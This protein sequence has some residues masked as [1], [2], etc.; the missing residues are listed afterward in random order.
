MTNQEYIKKFSCALALLLAQASFVKNAVELSIMVANSMIGE[1]TENQHELVCQASANTG[2]AGPI[3]EIMLNAVVAKIASNL[4]NDNHFDSKS[5][6]T[7]ITLDNEAVTVSI[8][9]K[10][11]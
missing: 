3:A 11:V 5:Q 9:K 6:F 7:V 8:Y 4:V 1:S 2:P 10:G